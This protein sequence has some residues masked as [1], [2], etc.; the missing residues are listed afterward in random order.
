MLPGGN[1]C[2]QRCVEALAA[3]HADWKEEYTEAA[4][5]GLADTRILAVRVMAD[6]G[7]EYKEALLSL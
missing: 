3:R 4:K 1:T 6:L 5:G 7:E 2:L